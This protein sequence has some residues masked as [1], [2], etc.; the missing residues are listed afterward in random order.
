MPKVDKSRSHK[1][2]TSFDVVGGILSVTWPIMFTFAIQEGGTTYSWNSSVIIGTLVA[3]IVG[4]FVFVA[5]EIQLGRTSKK[6]PVFPMRLLTN[7]VVALV[8]MQAP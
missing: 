7:P 4:L 6:E 5:W 1:N 3:G 2:Y 8:F